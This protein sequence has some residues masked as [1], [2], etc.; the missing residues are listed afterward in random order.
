MAGDAAAGDEKFLRRLSE[1]LK[2]P[3]VSVLETALFIRLAAI[4]S[5]SLAR[6]AVSIGFWLIGD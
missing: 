6:Y 5:L 3:M 1:S 4:V 2:A